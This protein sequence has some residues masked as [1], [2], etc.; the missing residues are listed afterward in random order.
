MLQ[1]WSVS[2]FLLIVLLI[3]FT[4]VAPGHAFFCNVRQPSRT[5]NLL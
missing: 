4:A 2:D 1:A 5:I 3:E